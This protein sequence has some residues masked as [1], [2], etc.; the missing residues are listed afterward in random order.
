MET[1]NEVM[2]KVSKKVLKQQINNKRYRYSN[3]K[4]DII[5]E[6]SPAGIDKS[7]SHKNS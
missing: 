6:E 1:M 4:L 7:K 2:H 5:G 3:N